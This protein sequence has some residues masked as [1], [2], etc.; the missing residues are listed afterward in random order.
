MA[1]IARFPS[2]QRQPKVNPLGVALTLH[3]EM[4]ATEHEDDLGWVR[5]MF[6]SIRIRCEA[7]VFETQVTDRNGIIAD[8]QTFTG[9]VWHTAVAPSLLAAWRAAEAND[10]PAL[11]AVS[12]SLS[13]L[14]PDAER[15]RSAIAGD[16]LLRATQGALHQGILGRLRQ[17]LSQSRADSHLAVVWAAVAVLFQMPP[18]DMITEYLREEWLTALRE[19]PQPHEPQGPLSFPAM[20]LRA[21]REN[22]VLGIGG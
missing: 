14:L 13:R 4:E 2:P 1:V 15:E 7:V 20:A 21:L 17:E 11:L 6:Q 3:T 8:W 12:E 22:G 10:L 19:H 5:W 9:G 16:L 18:A